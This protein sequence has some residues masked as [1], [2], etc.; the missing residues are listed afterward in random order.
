V[1][2]SPSF[3]VIARKADWTSGFQVPSTGSRYRFVRCPPER[4]RLAVP[5]HS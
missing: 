3:G 1:R 2:L 5:L 4:L